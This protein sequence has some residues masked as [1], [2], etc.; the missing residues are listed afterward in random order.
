MATTNK[1]PPSEAAVQHLNRAA[2]M[3]ADDRRA[4]QSSARALIGIGCALVA[5][6]E[7]LEPLGPMFDEMAKMWEEDKEGGEGRPPPTT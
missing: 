4:A 6:L 7:F 5:L 3:I 2:E 1:L